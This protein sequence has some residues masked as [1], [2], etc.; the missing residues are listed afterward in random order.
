[1]QKFRLPEIILCISSVL[2]GGLWGGGGG[3]GEG[4]DTVFVPLSYINA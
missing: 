1:M 3:G 4:D 2:K